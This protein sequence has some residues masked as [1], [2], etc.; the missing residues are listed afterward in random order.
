MILDLMKNPY[1]VNGADIN[2]I[3]GG[4]RHNVFFPKS[5]AHSMKYQ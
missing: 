5:E 3:G 1:L 2:R 4:G